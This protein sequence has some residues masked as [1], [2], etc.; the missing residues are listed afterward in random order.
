MRFAISV[1]ILLL[2][3]GGAGA[4]AAWGIQRVPGETDAYRVEVNGPD[5]ALLNETVDVET[6]TVL[7]ALQAAAAK[8][9]I[10]LELVDYA[11]M[12]TYVR[13]IDG[14]RAEGATGWI[15]EV[16]RDG[17]WQSGDRSAEFFSLQKGDAVRWTWT[18]G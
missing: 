18:A 16:E 2:V 6:A 9:G 10:D 8:A 13:A 1:L 17:A 11:G 12:G 4:L 5:G 14:I 15:Y 7:S 3:L